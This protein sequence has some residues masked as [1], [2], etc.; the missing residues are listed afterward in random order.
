MR[1]QRH[2]ERRRRYRRVLQAPEQLLAAV[3][4]EGDVEVHGVLPAALDVRG[5]RELHGGAFTCCAEHLDGGVFE[6]RF[7]VSLL[8]RGQ[9]HLARPYHR[10]LTRH[11]AQELNLPLVLAEL[12]HEGWRLGF[13]LVLFLGL[14]RVASP[15]TCGLACAR[16]L[17]TGMLASDA[18]RLLGSLVMQLLPSL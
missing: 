1:R 17:D 8:D 9:R 3:P 7:I 2:R 6:A 16:K 11:L 12:L 5:R 13:H 10:Y 4:A 15:G 18:W 14:G